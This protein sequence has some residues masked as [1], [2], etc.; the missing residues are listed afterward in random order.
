MFG[1]NVQCSLPI[2]RSEFLLFL[3]YSSSTLHIYTYNKVI[4]LCVFL[5]LRFGLDSKIVATVSDNGND[6]RAATQQLNNFGV[7]LYCLCHGLNLTVKNGLQLWKKEDNK[8][9]MSTNP[10]E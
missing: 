1:P 3:L 4:R 7:R 5:N 6:M 9:N 2:Y 10:T 8:Q